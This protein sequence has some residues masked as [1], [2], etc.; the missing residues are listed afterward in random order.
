MVIFVLA[1]NWPPHGALEVIYMP[2]VLYKISR[3]LFDVLWV[4][5]YFKSFFDE[6]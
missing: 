1:Y 2:S 4:V 6:C 5:N 3:I